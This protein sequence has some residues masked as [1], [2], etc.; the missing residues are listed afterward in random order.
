MPRQ[1]AISLISTDHDRA[2]MRNAIAG[3]TLPCDLWELVNRS[4]LPLDRAEDALRDLIAQGMVLRLGTGGQN[5]RD[6]PVHPASRRH[7]GER[8]AYRD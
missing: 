3:R 8:A 4:N 6:L 7:W 1:L 2:A 5:A